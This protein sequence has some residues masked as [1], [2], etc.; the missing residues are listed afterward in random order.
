MWLRVIIIPFAMAGKYKRSEKESS[1]T[2]TVLDL[3]VNDML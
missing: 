3:L 2:V 1:L